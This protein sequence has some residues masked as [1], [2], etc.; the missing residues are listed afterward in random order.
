M[1]IFKTLLI[2]ALIC[3]SILNSGCILKYQNKDRYLTSSEIT[4]I[5]KT[6]MNAEKE[7]RNTT[8][9]VKTNNRNVQLSGFVDTN[10]QQLLAVQIAMGIK[11]VE[12]VDNALILKKM[13]KSHKKLHLRE[14]SLDSRT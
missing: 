8:I 9:N 4:K 2:F 12:H 7:L 13:I 1:N 14:P 10:A 6:K 3:I 11:G 5:I